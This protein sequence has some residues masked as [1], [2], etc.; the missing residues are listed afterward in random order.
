MNDLNENSNDKYIGFYKHFKG[1]IYELKAIA[2]NSETLEDYVVYQ[3]CYGERLLWIR[4]KRMF[5]EK[6]EFNEKIVSRFEYI[7]KS[8]P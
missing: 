3:A 7:G 5:F 1:K 4:S 6:L 2:I 8:N